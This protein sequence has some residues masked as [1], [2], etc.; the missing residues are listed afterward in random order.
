MS[1]AVESGHFYKRRLPHFRAPGAIYHMRLRIHPSFGMLRAER[2]FQTIQ[3]A[4]MFV[5]NKTCILI[6]YVVMPSH[7]H[8]VC[9][10]LPKEKTLSAW[11]DYRKHNKIEE[12]SGGIKKFSGRKINKIYH[13][14]GRAFWRSEC[15]DRMVRNEKDLDTLVD[16][17]HGNPVRWGLAQRPEDYRWSSA[18]TIYSGKSEYENWFCEDGFYE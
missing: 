14:T 18:S 5:H 11:C 2:D 10:P 1:K 3:D 8:I 13:R 7:A 4:I 16:Y 15:F 12:I 17:V 6:A 9:Q